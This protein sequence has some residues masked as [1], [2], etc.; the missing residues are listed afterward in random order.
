MWTYGR[1]LRQKQPRTYYQDLWELCSWPSM[2]LERVMAFSGTQL[3]CLWR[4]KTER[5]MIGW[6]LP[7]ANSESSELSQALCWR[8]SWINVSHLIS[9]IYHHRHRDKSR[10]SIYLASLDYNISKSPSCSNYLNEWLQPNHVSKNSSF[11]NENE[12]IHLRT[13]ETSFCH[14]ATDFHQTI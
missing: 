8:E 5:E 10:H 12:R 3:S 14:W 4:K 1:R 13:S 2:D 11:I 6:F 7:G 9:S